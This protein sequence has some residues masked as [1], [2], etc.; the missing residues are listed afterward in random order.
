MVHSTLTGNEVLFLSNC[1]SMCQSRP[2]VPS[3]VEWVVCLSYWKPTLWSEMKP[4]PWKNP[5]LLISIHLSSGQCH[6]F[7]VI[8]DPYYHH[9][10]NLIKRIVLIN[11]DYWPSLEQCLKLLFSLL[12][13]VLC[14][15]ITASRRAKHPAYRG[16][17]WCLYLFVSM[18]VQRWPIRKSPCMTQ[19][20]KKVYSRLQ[21][22]IL[23]T[24]LQNLYVSC[25]WNCSLTPSWMCSFVCC[26]YMWVLRDVSHTTSCVW[27]EVT[28]AVR[29]LQ[30][31]SRGNVKDRRQ[32]DDTWATALHWTVLMHWTNLGQTKYLD[33]FNTFVQLKKLQ[34]FYIIFHKLYKYGFLFDNYCWV[35]GW[36]MAS[37]SMHWGCAMSNV[38][39]TPNVI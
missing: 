14:T 28:A 24:V 7:P 4:N 20:T 11:D 15:S 12:W 37:I 3:W 21:C 23:T 34:M 18:G 6:W 29:C 32:A 19:H 1:V 39:Q 16:K 25:M 9:Q 36:I 31:H 38:I 5:V 8:I 10:P 30:H 35:A 2:T 17:F 27:C 33:L 26:A 22:V 13:A